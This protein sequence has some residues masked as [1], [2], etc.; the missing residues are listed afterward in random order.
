MSHVSPHTYI[1]KEQT[2]CQSLRNEQWN[3]IIPRGSRIA[4]ADAMQMR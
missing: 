1:R 3:H 2:H 4:C